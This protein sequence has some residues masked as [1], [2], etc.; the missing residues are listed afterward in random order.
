M[1]E[2]VDHQVDLSDGPSDNGASKDQ[3]SDTVD[4]NGTDLRVDISDALS[5]KE[6]VKFTV[7]TVTTLVPRFAQPEFSVVRTHEEFVWLADRLAENVDYAGIIIPP[8]PPTPD[9]S[10]SREKLARL[11][12]GEG[13]MTREEY[14]KMKSELEAEYLATFKK[15]VAMHEVFLRRIAEHPK[16]RED[17]IFKVFLEYK[18]DLNVRGKNKKEKVQGFL[19][20]GWKTVDDVIL[21]AQKEKDE[22]F[23][24]QKKFITSYYSHLKTTLADADRMNRFHKNTAD[25]YIRVSSTV[26]DCSRMERDKC[27]ADFLFHYGEFCEKYRKLEGR[28][29]SDSDL[30]LADTLHYYVSDCTS[31]KD[32]MYRR[33]RALA[34]YETANKELEKA[35]TKNKAVKKAEDDQEAAYARFTAISESGRAELTEFKKRWVAY[36]HRSLVEHTELQIKHAKNQ[37]QLLRQSIEQLKRL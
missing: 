5:E 19:K 22:F 3:R 15:T 35:R 20:S 28:Q 11:G 18:E 36:F 32:L 25:A 30:K 31:A 9:F 24:G 17:E 29:A 14:D 1:L 26:Q 21:S 27:L 10:T 37:A 13:T 2:E 34:D 12:D 23:E 7:R 16:L 8:V 6:R 33:S 4:L